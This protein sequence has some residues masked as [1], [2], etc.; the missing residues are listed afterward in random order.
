MADPLPSR[1]I[2]HL[3]L[4][5][6]DLP[7]MLAFYRDTLGFTVRYRQEDQFAFLCLPQQPDLLIALYPGRA[8]GPAQPPHWFLVIDVDQIEAVVA[9]LGERGARVGPI[10]PVPFGR[11][12]MITDPEGNQIEIHQSDAAA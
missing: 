9:Q 7:T 5:T 2:S 11:A 12:A 1:R 6:H 10:E 3:F 8:R 4:F